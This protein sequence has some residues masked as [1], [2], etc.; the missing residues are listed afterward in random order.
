MSKV[1]AALMLLGAAAVVGA[2]FGAALSQ[3]SYSVGA[4]FYIEHLFPR[5]AVPE[6]LQPRIGAALVGLRSGVWIAPALMVPPL[7]LGWSALRRGRTVLIAGTGAIALGVTLALAGAM[8]GLVLGLIAPDYVDQLPMPPQLADPES[9][10]R[11]KVMVEGA[12]WGA[13]FALLAG[14]RIMWRARLSE[15]GPT[16]GRPTP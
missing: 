16:P 15:D 9:Y 5:Y 14:L 13:G 11:A 10:L 3:L 12:Y 1:R 6:T 8:V 4:S 7:L 2:L